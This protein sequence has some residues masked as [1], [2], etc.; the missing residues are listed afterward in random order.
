MSFDDWFLWT[1]FEEHTIV[2]ND[3]E[4]RS[5]APALILLVARRESARIVSHNHQI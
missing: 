2:C 1:E 5:A 4:Y 3:L